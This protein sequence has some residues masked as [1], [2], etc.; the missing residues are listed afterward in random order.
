MALGTAVT[1]L[2]LVSA[3]L[4][5]SVGFQLSVAA[6]MGV[7]VGV[8]WSRGR[9]PRWLWTSLLVT[10]FAQLA[11]APIILSVFGS[12]PLWAPAANLVVAPI[13]TAAT[14]AGGL[15]LVIAPLVPLAAVFSSIVL[16]VARWASSGPQ[17]GT[18]GVVAAV[19]IGGLVAYRSTRVLGAVA[20]LIVV[21][22][23][24]GGPSVWPTV[25]T[26]TALDVGQGDAILIQDPAGGV[27]L[28]DGGPDPGVIDRSLRRHGVSR[29]DIVVA[30]HGDADHVG[31]LAE[32][33]AAYDVG[34]LWVSAHT[35]PSGLLEVVM[36]AAVSRGV[37]IV[38]VETGVRVRLG[39]IGLE[40]LSPSRRFASD[41]DGSIV[42][43]AQAARSV[44]LP[45]DIE[46]IGQ[47]ELPE[48]RPDIMVV[49][50]HGSASTDVRWLAGVL[51]DVAVLSYGVN[52]YGHP[53]ADIMAAI[54]TSGTDIRET[55][56]EG[57]VVVSLSTDG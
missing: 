1:I 49:P 24:A 25:P 51:G 48:L 3:D 35:G 17:L 16:A 19:S 44:L 50:H 9:K 7:L 53:N 8:A 45:G 20:A 56:L 41:N 47:A 46:A 22:A 21:V 26:V 37:P 27:M 38:E 42:I 6:T 15:S 18:V 43:L 30:T 13:V 2:L 29:I 54:A 39:G 52:T 10:V 11:V 28:I 12:M 31:G 4:L 40:V 23:G 14:V 5:W 36:D 57:D 32:V 55:F 33:V 34:M